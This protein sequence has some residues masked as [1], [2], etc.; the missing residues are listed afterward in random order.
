MKIWVDKSWRWPNVKKDVQL[1]IDHYNRNEKKKKT[2]KVFGI[3]G[4]SWGGS[5]ALA[6]GYNHSEKEF[7]AIKAVGLLHPSF[8]NL[9]EASAQIIKP[10][11]V[12]PSQT[13][14]MFVRLFRSRKPIPKSQL[15]KCKRNLM[16][17]GL[18]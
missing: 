13:D 7:E 3:Y 16:T 4:Q 18:S 10:I 12:L 11:I 15:T 6:A 17:L 8:I 9:T 2:N 14:A 1:I 5:I